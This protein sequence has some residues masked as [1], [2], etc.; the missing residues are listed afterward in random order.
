MYI[1]P[2]GNVKVIDKLA[3]SLSVVKVAVLCTFTL[4]TYSI[5][6]T[7]YN[8]HASIKH[9]TRYL[10]PFICLAQKAPSG[11]PFGFHEI[12]ANSPEIQ[13]ARWFPVH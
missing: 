4:Y 8:K 9:Y 2:I 13:V 3:T 10:V 1:V 11:K 12:S 5:Q 7:I 6:Y